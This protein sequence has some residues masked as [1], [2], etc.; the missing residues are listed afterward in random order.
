MKNH[1]KAWTHDSINNKTIE[2]YT[3][4][5]IFDS[6][7]I[8]FDLDPCSPEGG[9]P[10]IPVK[11]YYTKDDDGLT[12]P[13]KGRV[14]C[15]PPYGKE[16]IKWIKKM[17]EHRNGIAIVFARTDTKWYHEYVKN[18]DAILFLKGRVKFIDSLGVTGKNGSGSGS[19]LVAW[20]KDNVD[21]L[22]RMKNQGHFIKA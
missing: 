3:P 5:S 19:M 11:Q 8:E 10:W 17:H 21:A 1:K 2:W 16:T 15:N 4:K 18:A 12:S 9:V 14:W 22:E 6:L 20:G 7:D 13:W